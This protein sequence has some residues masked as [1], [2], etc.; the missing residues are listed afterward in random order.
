MTTSEPADQSGASYS[1]VV[2]RIRD[3]GVTSAELA[4]IVG[5][6]ERQVQHWAAGSSKPAMNTRERL[7]DLF[8]VVDQLE[9]VYRPEGVEIWI[10]SRNKVLDGARPIDLLRRGEFGPVIDAVESLTHGAM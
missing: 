8:Y 7:I 4:N 5:V 9:E 10:H 3:A 2:G 6:G 1:L